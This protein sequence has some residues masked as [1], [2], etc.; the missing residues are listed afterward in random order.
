STA[1]GEITPG[2]V[3]F[4]TGLPPRLPGLPLPLPATAVKGHMAVTEPVPLTLPGAVTQVGVQIED[5]R[6]L[7][8]GTL[9]LDDTSPEV[10]PE[11]IERLRATLV[12]ALPSLENVRLTHQW[13]CWRPHHPDGLAVIDRVPGL[14]NAWLTSGHY[15][16]GIL[17]APATADALAGWI[18]T[19]RPRPNLEPWQIQNRFK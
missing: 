7:L 11:A 10:N 6:L 1:A 5:H 8:G 17:M 2:A 12:Q 18:A 14:T 13:C 3:V 15:R 4:A 16:T 19:G 9:D